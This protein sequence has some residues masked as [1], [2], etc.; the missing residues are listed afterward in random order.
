MITINNVE[1]ST[2]EFI[3]NTLF[4]FASS[5]WFF[6]LD[7]LILDH[8]LNSSISITIGSIESGTVSN[9]LKKSRK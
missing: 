4:D 7:F 8:G 9:G 3:F 1:K 6:F 2:L 5:M